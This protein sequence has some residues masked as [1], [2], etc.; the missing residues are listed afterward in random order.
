MGPVLSAVMRVLRKTR[1]P[2]EFRM[3]SRLFELWGPAVL[4]AQIPGSRRRS[5]LCNAMAIDRH[6]LRRLRPSAT[7]A[8]REAIAKR[9]GSAHAA[10]TGTATKADKTKA[11]RS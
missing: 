9:L 7:E 8:F 4:G 5:I 10:E 2:E 6:A 3:E 1:K 11:T